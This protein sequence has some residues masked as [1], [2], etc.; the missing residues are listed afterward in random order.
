MKPKIPFFTFIVPLCAFMLCTFNEAW[1][2]ETPSG[3]ME[4][5]QPTITISEE[6]GDAMAREAIR[7]KEHLKR[8]ARSM[9]EREPLG[10]GWQTID[11]L[12]KWTVTLPLQIPA[13]MKAVMEQSRVLGFVGSIIMLTFLVAVFYSLFGRRKILARIEKAMETLSVKLPQGVYPFFFSAV[14]IVVAALFPLMLLALYLLVNALID[15]QAQWFQL[16]GRMLGLWAFGAL[17]INLLRE[18]LTRDLFE[19]TKD[20]GKTVYH[21]TRLALLYAISGVALYWAAEVYNLR[22]DALALLRFAVSISIVF[23]L[24]ALHLNKKAMLSL[25]P[26]LP[27]KS[28][29]AFFDLVGRYYFPLIFF[30]LFAALLW[31]AGYRRL[32]SIVLFKVWITGAAYLAMMIIYHLLQQ[33]LSAW[34]KKTKADDDTAQFLYRSLRGALVYTTVIGTV[35]IVLNLMGLLSLLQQLISFPVFQLGKTI[36]TF[37]TIV[38]AG[39]I[40]GAFIYCSRLLQAY[41]DYKVYPS[42]GVDPGLG[43]ALNT[44]FKYFIF[45]V[46]FLTALRVMGV[47]LRLFLVFAGAIGIG[48]GLG[49]QN[50]AANVISGFTIIFGGKIRKGD[51]IEVGDTM[52]MVTDI[53]F[54]ATKVKTRDNIEYL[55]P[56]S[57]FISGTVVNY[58]LSSPFVRL[59][60]PVGVSYD[61]DPRQVEQILLDAARQEPMVV[62]YRQPDVR[63]TEYG[64]SSINFILLFWIDVRETARRKAKSALYFK[65]FDEFK[66]AGIQIPFPQREVRLRSGDMAT[67][68][69]EENQAK[70]QTSFATG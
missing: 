29:G 32:G 27:N 25:L 21:L 24:F 49:L 2:V 58:S 37:W 38:K 23:V 52:G 36:V 6:M 63:F 26:Q 65:I 51:W 5:G 66:K 43:Y 18:G 44:F 11:Y 53:Y 59:E 30:L 47:D 45:A 33:G 67:G 7:V 48:L 62:N 57:D 28:Y 15:Y 20:H 39:L 13:F 50:M 42:V 41:L 46:G 61:E 55:I 31:C 16:A 34:Y 12:Y 3:E 4:K 54:R 8:S 10:W 40:L 9:F 14:R 68:G 35:M 69:F 17:V 22:A 64:D 1:A 70:N 19:A 60:L 56:N